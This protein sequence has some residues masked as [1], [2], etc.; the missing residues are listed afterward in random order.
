MSHGTPNVGKLKNIQTRLERVFSS[1]RQGSLLQEGLWVVLIGKPNVGK[2][3]L[4]N[5]L[6]GEEAAIVTEI[7]GTTRDTVLRPI[8]IEGVPLH[9]LDT[10]GLRE[11]AISSRRSALPERAPPSKKQAWRCC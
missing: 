10:A 6:A 5:Q 8:A 3:S 4:S 11:T 7:P 2:S 9:L 1:A